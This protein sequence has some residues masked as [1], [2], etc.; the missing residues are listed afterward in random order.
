MTPS[1][2]VLA[3]TAASASGSFATGSIVPNQ[4]S[5]AFSVQ[6]QDSSGNA[7]TATSN[8]TI[9]LSSNSSTGEFLDL[10]GKQLAN[11]S[12]VI[13]AGSSF[14]LF[15]YEDSQTGYAF[16]T[17]QTSNASAFGGTTINVQ[18]ILAFTTPKQTLTPGQVSQPI[19]IQLQ[20]ADGNPIKPTSA[21]TVNL[22]SSSTGGK[23][24]DTSGKP[25]TNN[26]LTIAAGSSSASFEYEDSNTGSA[27]ISAS[28]ST[29][30]AGAQSET[31]GYSLAFTTPVQSIAT[32]QKSGAI[33]V[34][35][36]DGKGNV[37][38]AASAVTLNLSTYSGTG[39]FLDMSGKPLPK[40]TF[41]STLTVA[42]GSSSASFEFEDSQ[43][44]IPTISVAVSNGTYS[45]GTSAQQQINVGQPLVITSPAQT[46]TP[47][48]AS[49]P[50]TVQL[51]SPATSAVTLNL[52]SDSSTGQFLDTSG[53]ALANNSI[54]IAAG[55][56]SASFKYQ[57]SQAGLP[58]ISIAKGDF[59]G[60][61]S[62][63]ENVGLS[64]NFTTGPQTIAQGQL[65]QPITV[66]LQD[67][68]GQPSTLTTS[69]YIYL[70]GSN[71]GSFYDTKGSP[72]YNL[73]LAAGSSSISFEYKNTSSSGLDNVTAATSSF[74]SSPLLSASQQET[75]TA[76]PYTLAIVS[77]SQTFAATQASQPITVQLQKNGTAFTA[78]SAVTV[79]LSSSSS[80]GKFLDTSGKALA[81][82]SITIAAGS[83]SASFEYEDSQEWFPT[84]TATVSGTATT[85]TQTENVGGVS[86]ALST[87]A[88][89]IKTGQASGAITV[90][91]QDSS[92]KAVKAPSATTIGLS[93]NSFTGQFLDSSGKPLTNGNFVYIVAGS[94][95]GSFEFED[96][97][98]GKPTLTAYPEITGTA[99]KSVTQQET[100]TGPYKIAF[101]ASG[102]TVASNQASPAIT[103][104]LQDST[105]TAVTTSSAVTVSLSSS[106]STGKFLDTSGKA[107]VNNS[108]TIAAGSGTASFEYE[109]S[110]T[111]FPTL[112]ASENG[113]KSQQTDNIGVSLVFTTSP[114]TVAAGK[115]SQTITVQLQDSSGN[116]F[117]APGDMTV[118]LSS[119][120]QGVQFL[121]TS[122]NPL[123]TN[124]G[125]V[126]VTIAA[127]SSSA[128]FEF[129]KTWGGSPTLTA[130][131]GYNASGATPFGIS[132][133][134]K[135]TVQGIAAVVFTTSPQ[136]V[137]AG[138]TSQLVTLQL[139]DNNGK[140]ADAPSGGVTLNLFAGSLGD[141]LTGLN[142]IAT[143]FF[144]ANGNPLPSA[145][146]SFGTTPITIAEGSSTVSFEFQADT[147]GTLPLSA[148]VTNGFSGNQN[149]TVQAASP[150][151][152]KFVSPAQSQLA[153]T[154]SGT[155]TV[156]LLDQFGNVI[157][158]GSGGSTFGLSSSSSSGKFLSV[159]GDPLASPSITI[160]Q[161][162]SSASF[163]YEDSK[164]G[165]PTLTI[166]ASGISNT[167]QQ[168]I[169]STSSEIHVTNTNDSGAGS[170]RD[171]IASA[172][173]NPGSTIVFDSGVKGTIDLL[174]ALPNITADTN[175]LGPG[176]NVLTIE[177]SSSATDTFGG[178][179]IGAPPSFYFGTSPPPTV[180]TISGLTV[181]NFDGTGI[182]NYGDF[183]TLR[184]MD[185]SNNQAVSA[186]QSTGS[187]TSF[188]GPPGGIGNFGSS[189][190]GSGGG[191]N[192]TVL[193][194]TIANNSTKNSLVAAGIN[195]E[196]GSVIIINSTIAGN[197]D[198]NS[199]STGGVGIYGG[200][201]YIGNSTI[202]GNTATQQSTGFSGSNT[203]GGGIDAS[204][205]VTLYDTIVAGNT[206]SPNNPTDVSGTFISRGNNLIGRANADSKGFISTDLVGTTSK[207]I[208]PKLSGLANNGG[209]TPT[210]ALLTGS[211]AIAAGNSANAPATDQRGD[212]RPQGAIDIGAV[213]ATTTSGPVAPF[214]TGNP[215]AQSAV[216]GDNVSFTASATGNPTPTVQWQ[217]SSN[218]TNWTN[219]SDGNGV[220]GSAM[221]TLTLSNVTL[222]LNNQEYRAVFTNS[223][224]SATS[225]AAMLTVTQKAV[226]PAIT[227]NP[228]N[229]TVTDTTTATFTASASGSPTPT[230][231]WQV[232]TDG[233]NWTKLSDGNGVSGSATD[234]LTLS[235]VTKAMSGNEYQA[236]FTNSVNSATTSAATLTV[237]AAV[238]PVI[239]GN[240]SNQ[241]ATAGQSA[242]FTAS[243]SGAPTPTVQWQ[244]STDGGKTFSNIGGATGTTLTL[245]NVTTAM[246]GYQYHAVFTNAG[247]SVTSTAAKLTVHAAPP[248]PPVSAPPVLQTPPLLQFLNSL[249][250]GGTVTIN[251]DGTETVTDTFFGI[252]L[253]V[254]TFDSSGKLVDAKLFG[255][256][257]TFLIMLL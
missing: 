61:A 127:G 210:L 27:N 126:G 142:P 103:V 32:T 235:N 2:D 99:L 82:N 189:L 100:V 224:S 253:I 8:M 164:A 139:E 174:T 190:F 94:S 120:L 179:V 34:Q 95:S 222:S 7:I 79:S 3:F 183:L 23:F 47:G 169:T 51:D 16:I 151:S 185:V 157:Q 92:G 158:A 145:P 112:T 78:P 214:I 134:Q 67:S 19:T 15:E 21:V 56:S 143:K 205:T 98:G 14:T 195:S 171:A 234:T 228:S 11:S 59:S 125:P 12:L 241:T 202:S 192:L 238:G 165:T 246:N 150:H 148:I 243:A 72:L 108:I 249:F 55:S 128:S 70:S 106:S 256:D 48:Q 75:V 91:F 252:P 187:F 37:V 154:P 101:S 201:A 35:L 184:Q 65:S 178:F 102:L 49:Q 196:G 39:Q 114:Q 250:G 1:T 182:T 43:T 87:A 133:T 110:Q 193:D 197:V 180:V 109:D 4:P 41:G 80:T 146:G 57:D 227:A 24:L 60:F 173:N 147:A 96:T 138:Q 123:S 248:P 97:V 28:T 93:S 237:T 130:S 153:G 194:S 200:T 45:V 132:A 115:T 33:T 240:P 141:G 40:N 9:K 242:T 129:T 13:P 122:G 152:V 89:T 5:T 229:Q 247:G 104:Q 77:P 168:T 239:T 230:V 76:P 29:G 135:E 223:V 215:I 62:Q 140:I 186:S 218:G 84:L 176:A 149:E 163:Q 54:T 208:D 167:Q 73:T 26:S 172:D 137:T 69:T 257:I 63:Q 232:S 30:A 191:G 113:F 144:D 131:T 46:L 213:E 17:G 20:D 155:M 221:D 209:P 156:Q 116:A 160:P 44:G 162:A 88:Q 105:D 161:G 53:K 170:L 166:T 177:R 42:A 175:I 199:N 83:S 254:S 66:Q 231:Q 236:V 107:L 68:K 251:A 124:N 233:K 74:G 203:S 211:P 244:V 219:L 85:G 81:N 90:H 31:I 86:F 207:S 10:S 255:I 226:A 18:N 38:K 71:G 198:N 36:Q 212:A 216:V 225:T 121:D 136:T 111:G 204:G 206:G 245:N 64:L 50:I 181:A 159:S 217:V 52:R 118:S 117:K 119:D 58:T 22:S 25:L 6:L 220:S 188:Y